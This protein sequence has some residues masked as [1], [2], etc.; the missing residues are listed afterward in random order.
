MNTE[1]IKKNSVIDNKIKFSC[2]KKQLKQIAKRCIDICIKVS[3]PLSI[4]CAIVLLL[5]IIFGMSANAIIT[6]IITGVSS[7]S[8]YIGLSVL[9]DELVDRKVR[10]DCSNIE[11]QISE[12]IT[13]I[14]SEINFNDIF[15]ILMIEKIDLILI[16]LEDLNDAKYRYK[17]ETLY[18]GVKIELDK[19]LRKL[20]DDYA[21]YIKSQQ[22]RM[23]REKYN[24]FEDK[25]LTEN[26][27]TQNNLDA[28]G[29]SGGI[30]D[31]NTIKNA[32]RKLCKKYH[33]DINKTT[34]AVEKIKKIN[35]AYEALEKIYK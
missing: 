29:L 19:L 32:Y 31:W 24:C 28:L 17:G 1:S 11:K 26:T 27:K 13:E 4:F 21:Y 23:K 16:F 34:D 12:L 9:K 8:T 20:K 35:V 14:R 5:F 7:F 10:L 18:Y 15:S 3:L 6:V 25:T 22:K 33:T 2:S 30:T